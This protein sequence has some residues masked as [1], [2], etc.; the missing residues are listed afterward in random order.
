M[1]VSNR[2]RDQLLLLKIRHGDAGA[3]AEVYDLYVDALFR[4][5]LFRVPSEEVAQ[6][7]ASDLFLRVWERLTNGLP[8]TNLRAYLYQV[9]RNLVADYYRQDQ[10]LQLFE[11]AAQSASQRLAD[12][13]QLASQVSLVEIERSLRRLKPEWQEVILLAYVEGFSTKE[14]ADIIGKSHGAT[15]T[16]LHRALQELKHLLN[17]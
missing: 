8:V 12:H 17:Q 3:Y 9:A 1:S 2:L 4:Y 13:H 14:V 15:R 16:I 7:L 6:D 10:P 5:I 11:G